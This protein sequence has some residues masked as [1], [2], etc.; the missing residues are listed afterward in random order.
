VFFDE[1]AAAIYTES[2]T[3]QHAVMNPK[4]D[5]FKV[6]V[7]PDE[8]FDG[9]PSAGMLTVRCSNARAHQPGVPRKP[10]HLIESMSSYISSWRAMLEHCEP[11]PKQPADQGQ[12]T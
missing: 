6:V 4:T 2:E 9:N 8:D 5:N 12:V 11:I 3:Q 1:S 7:E 10:K